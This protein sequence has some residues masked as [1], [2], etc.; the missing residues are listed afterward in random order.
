MFKPCKELG[1]YWFRQRPVAW[2]HQTIT[3]TKFDLS[4]M[5]GFVLW[6]SC[7]INFTEVKRRHE[8]IKWVCKISTLVKLPPHLSAANELIDSSLN[9]HSI[10]SLSRSEDAKLCPLLWRHN[11]LDGVSNHQPCHC[12]LSRLFGCRSKKTSKLR[13]TGLCAGNS[14]GTGEFPAQMASNAENVSISWCHHVRELCQHWFR[15][16]VIACVHL[17]GVCTYMVCALTWCVHLH[18]WLVIVKG[19]S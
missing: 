19:L 6:H 1:R 15:Y 14:P 13:V 10:N 16:W 4:L 9:G 17:H 7:R 12:L 5:M 18:G 8:F 11:G 2:W 3:W